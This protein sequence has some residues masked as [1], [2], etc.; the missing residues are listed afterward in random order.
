MKF[1]ALSFLALPLPQIASSFQL[2]PLREIQV[3]RYHGIIIR[4]PVHQ[5]RS[6]WHLTAYTSRSSNSLKTS[7]LFSLTKLMEDINSSS[8]Q[9]PYPRLVFVGGKGGVGKTSISSALSVE[10]ASDYQNDHRVLVV[11]TDPAH[12][13]GDALD[14]DLRSGEGKPVVS[15]FPLFSSLFSGLLQTYKHAMALHGK[16]DL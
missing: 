10:L 3:D 4:T 12:S 16:I 11:S 2:H 8:G 6:P 9:G 14:V 1:Y 5:L 7:E 15:Y 13:L